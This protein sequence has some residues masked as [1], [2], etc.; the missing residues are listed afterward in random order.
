MAA[1]VAA[2]HGGHIHGQQRRA[3]LRVVPVQKMA[4]MA[5]Q[6][7]QGGQRGLNPRQK[8][9]CAYPAKLA[10][11]AGAEQVHADVGGRGAVRHDVVRRGLQVVGR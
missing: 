10:G 6:P 7:G 9:Q 3:A 8:F 11:A 2:V 1:E 4:A 5:L